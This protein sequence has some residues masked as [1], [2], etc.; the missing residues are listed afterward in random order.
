MITSRLIEEYAI[1]GLCTWRTFNTG[2]TSTFTI[3]VPRGS[4]ILLRQI[5][6]Y[7]FAPNFVAPGSNPNKR[8]LNT[9]QLTLIDQ[10]G[11]NEI[12]YL[13]RM[14]NNNLGRPDGLG[15]V[16]QLETW[17]TFKNLC[18]IDIGTTPSPKT[19]IF[20]A[21]TTISEQA[22]ERPTPLGYNSIAITPQVDTNDIPSKNFYP[23]GQQRQFTGA[24]Y[25][26]NT[27]DR[28]RFNFNAASV[29]PNPSSGDESDNQTPLFTFGYWEF[30]NGIPLE[31][32]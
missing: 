18:C 16:I 23:T 2:L 32:F 10:G 11:T 9:I 1:K 28:L 17:Q 24:P 26:G 12:T 14:N 3:P 8:S 7:P 21:A 27:I 22:Q 15:N 4:F 5:I 6:C 30:K 25:A 29:I 31:L 20:G 13:I 19:M